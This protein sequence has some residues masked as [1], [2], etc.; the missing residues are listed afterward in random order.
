[1]LT[2]RAAL[3]A[4]VG[5]DPVYGARP[6]KRAIQHGLET[7]LAQAILRGDFSEED[8]ICVDLAPDAPPRL[9]LERGSGGGGAGGN[10]AAAGATAAAAPARAAKE[11]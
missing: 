7:I 4:Q 6:V 1:V 9:V 10:G 11:G 5:Y 2:W 8:T 3:P